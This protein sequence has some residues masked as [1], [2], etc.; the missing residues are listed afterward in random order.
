MNTT[1]GICCLSKAEQETNILWC[2]A[3]EVATVYTSHP[4]DCRRLQKNPLATCTEV[5]RDDRD[6]ITGMEFEIPKWAVVIRMQ[7]RQVSEAQR[8]VL[9][10]ARA[11]Q[12]QKPLRVQGN[13]DQVGPA[14]GGPNRRLRPLG[15]AGE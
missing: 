3:S 14:G 10:R 7:R 15:M 5:R 12:G 9:S 1:A 8:R 2:A 13:S 4:S 6:R 11:S